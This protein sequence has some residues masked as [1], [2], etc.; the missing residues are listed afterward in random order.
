MS[1]VDAG[2]YRFDAYS[3]LVG[4]YNLIKKNRKFLIYL[5]FLMVAMNLWSHSS[6]KYHYLN[7]NRSRKTPFRFR[8]M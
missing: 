8:L 5:R 6:R 2:C 4:T 3:L 7:I 1:Y